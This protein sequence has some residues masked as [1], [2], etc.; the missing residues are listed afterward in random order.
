MAYVSS[1]RSALVTWRSCLKKEKKN[2][3][4]SCL[5]LFVGSLFHSL[6]LAS[7]L[8]SPLRLVSAV[9]PSMSSLEAAQL[10]LTALPSLLKAGCS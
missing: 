7:W 10:V 3:D 4:F 9:S 6:E 1:F 5:D 2:H 8:L